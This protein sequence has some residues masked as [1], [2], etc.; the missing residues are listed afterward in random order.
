MQL[1]NTD[2]QLFCPRSGCEFYQDLNNPIQKSG[3]YPVVSETSR[4]HSQPCVCS[5][6]CPVWRHSAQIPWNVKNMN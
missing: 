2:L 5:F 6:L 3:T 1:I 4:R